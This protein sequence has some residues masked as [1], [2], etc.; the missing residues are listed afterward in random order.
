[1]KGTTSRTK[2][3][4]DEGAAVDGLH[5]PRT[6][7]MAQAA[8]S[9]LCPAEL[10]RDGCMRLYHLSSQHALL[11]CHD[12]ACPECAGNAAVQRLQ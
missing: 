12:R 7:R 3:G 8:P 2:Q 9:M 4:L 1:M 6:V 11:C 5:V 10:C